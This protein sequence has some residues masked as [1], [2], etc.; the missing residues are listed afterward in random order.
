MVET[1]YI[2]EAHLLNYTLKSVKY[3]KSEISY[4]FEDYFGQ[5]PDILVEVRFFALMDFPFIMANPT[6][7]LCFLG[8]S[9]RNV[10]ERETEKMAKDLR[11]LMERRSANES[12]TDIAY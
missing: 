3:K 11:N 10:L 1:F 7:P 12:V 6:A 9:A 5:L 4:T 2:R 8:A